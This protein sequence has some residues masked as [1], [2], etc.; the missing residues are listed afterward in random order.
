[1]GKSILDEIEDIS[2]HK[3]DDAKY[4]VKNHK[5]FLIVIIILLSILIIIS[6]FA[7]IKV[8]MQVQR[9]MLEKQPIVIPQI[10]TREMPFTTLVP[11]QEEQLSQII[12]DNRDEAS[13]AYDYCYLADFDYDYQYLGDLSENA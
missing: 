6:L 9:T 8:P 1:M 13:V 12:I 5:K 7:L 2:E 10:E 11:Y 3:F 4:Y